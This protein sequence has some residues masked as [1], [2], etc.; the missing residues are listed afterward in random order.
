MANALVIHN[1][2]LPLS[3]LVCRAAQY[4]RMSTDYQ[5]YSIENQAAVIGAYAQ[6]HKLTIVRTYRDEG[7]S[8]LMIKNR[9]GLSQLLEDVRSGVADFHHVLVY[10]VSRW[11]RFQDIDES[12]HYEFICKQ[13]GTNVSY[14]AEQFDNDGSLISSILKNI[15]RAMAAE[16]SRELSAKVHA[17]Q[18][19]LAGL[20]FKMGG[21]TCY[22][23][24]RVVIDEKSRLRILTDGEHK[25]LTTDHVRIRPGATDERTV[26]RWIFEE[27]LRGRS[28]SDIWRELNMRGVP[29]KGAGPWKYHA[30][31]K[32]L[33]NEIYIGHLVFNRQSRN[34]GGKQTRN[35][36][37]RWIRSCF[38]PI[39]DR[40][41]FLRANRR[42]ENQHVTISDEEMLKRVRKVLMK[43]GRVTGEIIDAAPGL[44]ASNTYRRRFGSLKN[45]YRLL[46]YKNTRYWDDLKAYQCWAEINRSNGALLS[47][48][49]QNEGAQATWDS[50]AGCLWVND[51]V[52]ICFGLAKWRKYEGRP[53]RWTMYLRQPR[54]LGWIV[55]LRLGEKNEAILDHVLLPSP[56]VI[57]DLFWFSEKGRPIQ[58]IE[59]FGT[60]EELAQSLVSRVSKAARITSKRQ[61]TET[62][63]TGSKNGQRPRVTRR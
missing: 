22:G 44:P 43:K 23:L 6:L 48:A 12:A 13:A 34:L 33:R 56:S 10:D 54:A 2:K 27:Y 39:I 3:Q 62:V 63:I 35:P 37:E 57:S 5:Q 25:F 53:V 45:V 16:Y 8:G 9:R 18:M 1:D 61:P 46:D 40:D 30:I 51:A 47:K 42:L 38:E 49:F 11:G 20:G 58:K 19:R 41:V 15:K 50:Q 59:C 4:V 31:G 17:G 14:C 7:E 24:E 55:A 26:V 52:S 32:I 29:A 28:Q 60:F 36:E 21:P